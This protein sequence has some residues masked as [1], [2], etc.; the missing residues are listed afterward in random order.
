MCKF[1]SIICDNIN[2]IPSINKYLSCDF[3]N[4]AFTK[5]FVQV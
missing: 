3:H 5:M 4:N 1:Y 2:W